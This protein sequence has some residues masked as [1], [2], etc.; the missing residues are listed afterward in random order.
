[1]VCPNGGKTNH[2]E[3]QRSS[4]APAGTDAECT[5]VARDKSH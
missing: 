3:A 1:M 2:A 5:I 4:T